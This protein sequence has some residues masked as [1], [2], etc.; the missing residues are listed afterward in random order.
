MLAFA[1]ACCFDG[2]LNSSAMRAVLR[3]PQAIADLLTQLFSMTDPPVVPI[4]AGELLSLSHRR[5]KCSFSYFLSR[6]NLVC[7]QKP[8]TA[9]R[10]RLLGCNT[11]AANNQDAGGSWERFNAALR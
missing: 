4:Q 5:P 11:M 6:K 9:I 7:A 8:V 10:I 3:V 2:S 1:R